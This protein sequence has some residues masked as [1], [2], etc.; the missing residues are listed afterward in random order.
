M[1]TGRQ[2]HHHPM[3]VMEMVT[4]MVVRIRM[5]VEMRLAMQTKLV[6]VTETV[7]RMVPMRMEVEMELHLG[8]ERGGLTTMVMVM[9]MRWGVTVVMETVTTTIVQT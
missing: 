8:T 4:K 5:G 6:M 2:H 9:E 1:E 7:M 3:T